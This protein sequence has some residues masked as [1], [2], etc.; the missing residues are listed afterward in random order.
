MDRAVFHAARFLFRLQVS[1]PD[2]R[3]V[4]FEELHR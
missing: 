3:A 2:Y 1:N 4:H